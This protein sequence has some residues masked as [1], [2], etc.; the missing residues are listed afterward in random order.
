MDKCW[1]EHTSPIR[2]WQFI[3]NMKDIHSST[4]GTIKVMEELM[5]Q[6]SKLPCMQILFFNFVD[7]CN[8][9]IFQ[10]IYTHTSNVTLHIHYS[11]YSFLKN[12]IVKFL[13]AIQIYPLLSH[14]VAT[15]RPRLLFVAV[16]RTKFCIFALQRS[17]SYSPSLA[18]AF[19]IGYIA[20][21]R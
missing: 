2:K 7:E 1:S 17:F 11:N 14:C 15:L 19:K 8:S 5:V 20:L 9:L 12:A 6:K 18:A 16:F 21:N 4:N 10:G 3:R 13:Q